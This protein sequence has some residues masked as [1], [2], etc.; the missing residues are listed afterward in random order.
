LYICEVVWKQLLITLLKNLFTARLPAQSLG[1]FA[2]INMAEN[3][4]SFVLYTDIIHVFSN[5]TDDEA[6]KLIKH[7]LAYV[8]DQNP[9]TDNR[10]IQIAFEPIKLQLKRDL[11]H[12]ESVINK[13]KDAGK[14]GGL[15]KA[16]KGKQELANLAVTDTVNVTVTDTVNVNV[17]EINNIDTFFLD[18]E[19][20]S[21]IVEIARINNFTT[22]QVKNKLIEFR[23][24]AELSYPNYGKFVSHFKNWIRKN[25]PTNNEPKFVC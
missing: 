22:Y 1:V 4:K 20:G 19:N 17:N 16:S 21:H 13:R 10:I 12:W 14:L 5:L 11:K 8:N 7:L 2:L 18:F 25:P 3:K 23:T 6:G 9:I 24:V 15:A